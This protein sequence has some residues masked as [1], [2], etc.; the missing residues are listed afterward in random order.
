MKPFKIYS[1][2]DA[3]P[4]SDNL[5][6]A[7]AEMLGFVPNIFAV[8]AESSPALNAFIELNRQFSESSFDA[9]SR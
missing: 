9:T 3:Q 1:V 4:P 7:V 8:I 2:Q 5:L 6:K